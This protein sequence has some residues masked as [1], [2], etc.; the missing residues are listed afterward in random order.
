MPK[1]TIPFALAFVL[2]SSLCAA[3]PNYP[4]PPVATSI[5]VSDSPYELDKAIVHTTRIGNSSVYF[6]Q[7]R[8]GSLALAFVG[9][10]TGGLGTAVAVGINSENVG[11]K[12][13]QMASGMSNSNP[14][15]LE[16]KI[17]ADVA[18]L[19]PNLMSA[20]PGG[21]SLSG[22]L[23]VS[24]DK[25]DQ[26]RSALLIHATDTSKPD[27]WSKTYFYH[28]ATLIPV[29]DLEASGGFDK[30]MSQLAPDMDHAVDST[31]AV[32]VDD[33]GGKFADGT[34][35]KLRSDFLRPIGNVIIAYKALKIAER[36]NL[37]VAR[38]DGKPGMI[39]F[40]TVDGVHV[41][42]AGQFSIEP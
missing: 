1:P 16:P 27:G 25:D 42:Q 26:V 33:L 38:V 36:D 21:M 24:A 15:D 17:R 12:S 10:L 6:I 2:S 22:A 30:L 29:K 19:A 11:A 3:A 41:F 9:I 14:F 8:G 32:I 7:S 23:L 31:M 18:R 37:V 40:P 4:A 35:V 28:F 39:L 20:S 34:P 5:Q 13:A